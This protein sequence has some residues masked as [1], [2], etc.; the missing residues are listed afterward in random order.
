MKNP[1]TLAETIYQQFPSA[2]LKSVKDYACCAFTFMWCMEYE[3]EDIEAILTVG[4]MLDKGV[5]DP[6]CT[7]YW[8]KVSRYLTGRSCSV[9][10]VNITSISK[11]KERTPVYYERTYK[12]SSGATRKKGHWVGVENGKIKFNA[13]KESLCVNNGKPV[14]ARIL[15]FSGGTK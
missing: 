10:K 9:E 3:P 15:H 14:M 5:I 1:Q 8:D 2:K 7:V 4:R 12:D 6:D 13:L 11:I